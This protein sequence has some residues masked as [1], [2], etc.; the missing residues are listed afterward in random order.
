MR[1]PA[2]FRWT[3]ATVFL[4]VILAAATY[5]LLI[6]PTM[7]ATAE[8]RELAEEEQFRIDQL[9]IQLAGLQADAKNLE[10]FRAELAELQVQLPTSLLLP[11][12]SRHH[13]GTADD[14]GDYL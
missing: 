5:M 11:E 14:S 10:Q 13:D 7:D 1:N 12:L 2:A 4:A 6:M 9:E 8:A 3:I